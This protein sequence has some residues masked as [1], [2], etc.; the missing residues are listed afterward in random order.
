MR[1]T[2]VAAIATAISTVSGIKTITDWYTDQITDDMLPLVNI[3]DKTDDITRDNNV[4]HH[5]L[6]VVVDVYTNGSTTSLRGYINEIA[7]AVQLIKSLV[8]NDVIFEQATIEKESESNTIL[9]GS[10][11]FS[12]F[13]TTNP[14]TMEA[15]QC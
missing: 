8:V 6:T 15:I 7:K 2:I 5:I 13:Y 14:E 3:L 4:N 12:V 11:T 1:D 9:I 10:L